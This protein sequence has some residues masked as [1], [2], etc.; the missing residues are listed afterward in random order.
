VT[1]PIETAARAASRTTGRKRGGN[2]LRLRPAAVTATVVLAVT[3]LFGAAPPADAAPTPSATPS[4]PAPGPGVGSSQSVIGQ[5]ATVRP[6]QRPLIV[7]EQDA[8][9]DQGTS[10]TLGADVLFD[11]GQDVLSPNASEALQQLSDQI[12]ASGVSGR[13][14]VIGHTDDVGTP[15]VNLG[16]SNRRAATVAKR[17]TELLSGRGITLTAAGRGESQPLAP[18]KDAA[19][20]ARNRRVSV[21][22]A[23]VR[24]TAPADSSD[25]AVPGYLPVQAATGPAPEG[26]MIGMTRTLTLGSDRKEYRVR[27]D[28]TRVTRLGS[29]VLVETSTQ[30]QSGA[31]LSY[32]AALFT[33]HLYKTDKHRTALYDRKAGKELPIVVDGAGTL[34]CGPLSESLKQGSPR[35]GWFLFPAP[36]TG[37]ADLQLYFPAFGLVTVGWSRGDAS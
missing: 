36:S 27:L 33:G 14:V 15:D 29:M 10:F 6:V 24:P 8:E 1:T 7:I 28:I 34:L 9:A 4:F 12:V 13:A 23:G 17:L 16:L 11:T 19:A 37:D 20:R 18:N 31:D 26:S 30:L 35:H 25:V 3:G 21:V 22:F 32:Y 5:V 2:G